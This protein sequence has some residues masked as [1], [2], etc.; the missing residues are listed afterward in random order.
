[1]QPPTNALQILPGLQIPLAELVF[2][3]DRSPGPGGQNVN[4]TNTRAELRFDLERSPSLSETQRQRLRENLAARLSQEGMLIL[5]SSRFRSQLRNREDCVEKFVALL[6][7]HLQPPAPPRRPTRP[8]R[9]A[10]ARRLDHK[11]SHSNKKLLR[12][13]PRQD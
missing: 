3:F 7:F 1:M 5:N 9:A 8:G 13:P 2:T 4:K 6:A 11:K 12:R 10:R